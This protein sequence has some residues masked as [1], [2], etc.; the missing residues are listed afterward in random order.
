MMRTRAELSCD[1][2]DL[3]DY[4]RNRAVDVGNWG[5]GTLTRAYAS[6]I[7]IAMTLRFLLGIN[8]FAAEKVRRSRR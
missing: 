7:V 4:D 3:T 8:I 6:T 5:P 2:L 1:A